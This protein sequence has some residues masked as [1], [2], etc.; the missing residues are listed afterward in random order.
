MII[1]AKHNIIDK[2]KNKPI[3]E[4]VYHLSNSE[5]QILIT[6]SRGV[7]IRAFPTDG[8]LY[9]ESGVWQSEISIIADFLKI[10]L[11][12]KTEDGR[13]IFFGSKDIIQVLQ[14]WNWSVFE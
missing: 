13:L 7:R 10:T 11:M 4:L 8:E 5:E 6:M 2:E 3:A 14:G 12:K 1:E 9:I